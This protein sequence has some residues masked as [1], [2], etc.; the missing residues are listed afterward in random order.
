MNSEKPKLTESGVYHLIQPFQPPDNIP[1]SKPETKL[2]SD[3]TILDVFYRMPIRSKLSFIVAISVIIVAVILISVT[4]QQQEKE[5]RNQTE[6]LGTSIVQSLAAAAKENL[7]LSSYPVI[8]DYIKAL[9]QRRPI[10]GLEAQY[11]FD[12]TGT[13]VA[14]LISDSVNRKVADSELEMVKTTDTILFLET[15]HSFRYVLP[16]YQRIPDEVIPRQILLGGASVSFSKETLLAPIDRIK[17]LVIATAIFVCLLGI[18]LMFLVSGRFV[19][20]LTSLSDAARRVGEGDLLVAVDTKIKDEL[21]VLAHEFNK[22]VQ[23]L[24]E[25]T[26]M[27]KYLSRS[28]VEMLSEEHTATLGGTRKTVTVMFT[29]IRDFTGASETLSPEEVVETL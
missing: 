16:I 6:V 27:Q 20:V 8:Q 13:I 22:M 29:D 23:Q 9:V 2:K 10:P 24:R 26:E 19:K 4:L 28:A 25:K 14:H 1:L 3:G 18:A 7:L 15:E 5:L 11:V 17:R 12:R 21:G